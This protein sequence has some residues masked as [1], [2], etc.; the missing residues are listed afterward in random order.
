MSSSLG[1][2]LVE[3]REALPELYS[4]WQD[5]PQ[6]NY[7]PLFN[8]ADHEMDN[9]NSGDTVIFGTAYTKKQLLIAEWYLSNL[10]GT[11]FV[12]G[13]FLFN[14]L[15]NEVCLRWAAILFIVGSA[16]FTASAVLIFLRNDCASFKDMSLSLNCIM[17]I[18]ANSFFVVGSFFFLPT[19]EK[20][21]DLLITG[22]YCFVVGSTIFFAGPCY[23][24]Y[25]LFNSKVLA[26]TKYV[27]AEVTVSALYIVGNV[28]FIVGSVLFLPYHFK[29]STYFNFAAL[30][31]FIVGSFC[32]FIATFTLT[33][34]QG[35]EE[36]WGNIEADAEDGDV[37]RASLVLGDGDGD[38]DGDD[39]S[40][41]VW[42]DA[43][44]DPSR[45]SADTTPSKVLVVPTV[46]TAHGGEV[47]SPVHPMGS[48]SSDDGDD[49]SGDP[50]EATAPIATALAQ[51]TL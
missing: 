26:E 13:S 18:I 33:I 49:D 10:A 2:P 48:S 45:C 36:L 17:Y 7:P 6:I 46:N 4:P 27:T 40:E 16:M 19:L 21:D 29:H 5:V 47:P 44:R 14:P 30:L 41:A 38:G 42:R 50:I 32:F 3:K 24:V 37:E 20:N 15:Y 1:T 43:G 35:M 31:L 12:V 11:M 25:R 22:L 51:Y 23:S 34:K 8:E 39:G 28:M 9:Q